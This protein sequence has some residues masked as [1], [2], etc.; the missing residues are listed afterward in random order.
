MIHDSTHQ[1]SASD[2]DF[3][4]HDTIESNFFVMIGGQID[5]GTDGT[6]EME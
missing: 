5:E 6:Q 4:E 2:R 3:F 1:M